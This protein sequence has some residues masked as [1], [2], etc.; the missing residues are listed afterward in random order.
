[1][2]R[3]AEATPLVSVLTPVLNAGPY[4]DECIASVQN[5]DYPNV[6]HVFADGGSTDGSLDLLRS[7]AR[8]SPERFRLH[9]S[10]DDRGV[11][12]GLRRAASIS[13]G[14]VLGWLD[15]DDRY[16]PGAI[17]AAI[18]HLEAEPRRDFIYGRC[19][20]MDAD[21]EVIG[22]FV[23]RDFDRSEWVN[24]WHYM[25]FCSA[26]F[27]REVIERVGFVNDLGNDLDWYLRIAREFELHR[28][29]DLF[30]TWRLHSGGI[31]LKRA[32]RESS[33]RRDRARE[34]FW[35]VVRNHG[36]LLSPRALTYLAVAQPDVA[37]KL[38]PLVGRWYPKLRGIEYGFKRSIAV[39]SPT[40]RGG[41]LR[42]LIRELR[43][44]LRNH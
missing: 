17:S 30:A 19:D 9:V 12:S 13:R 20:I 44:S 15:S 3:D 7:L 31:S 18:S 27:R 35:L 29:D 33:I 26:F 25:V 21:S 39:S 8:D 37:R 6:E 32:G 23:I 22:T 4:L 14:A 1:M 11:G 5:Q 16:E 36:S 43:E 2:S 40:D 42:P 24:R 10:H 38:R 41:Y 34:D 28:V